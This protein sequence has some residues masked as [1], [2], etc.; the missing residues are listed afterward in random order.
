MILAPKKET[1]SVKAKRL[2]RSQAAKK[3]QATKLKEQ[4]IKSA[5]QAFL[6]AQS[7]D[8][9]M[10]AK[11]KRP[12]PRE[13]GAEDVWN[14][15]VNSEGYWNQYPDGFAA[16]W[17]QMLEENAFEP[18]DEDF[19]TF[20]AQWGHEKEDHLMYDLNLSYEKKQNDTQDE[21][22]TAAMKK[23]QQ[24]GQAAPVRKRKRPVNF[25]SK[26]GDR[27]SVSDDTD[28]SELSDEPVKKTAKRYKT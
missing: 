6:S 23:S 16:A 5:R 13:K 3:A 19:A 28:D 17:Y 11:Y 14:E 20:W 8:A 18:S 9:A 22:H 26:P 15:N 21:K 25:F 24:D 12:G 10:R 1:P 27:Y 2:A 7:R 4:T